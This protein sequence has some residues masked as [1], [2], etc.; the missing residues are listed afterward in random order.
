MDLKEK[1]KKNP[2]VTDERETVVDTDDT[3][4]DGGRR[5]MVPVLGWRDVTLPVTLVVLPQRLE[6]SLVRNIGLNVKTPGL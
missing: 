6:C 2:V 4:V 5:E 1:V 3:T